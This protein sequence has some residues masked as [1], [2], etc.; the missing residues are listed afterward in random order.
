MLCRSPASFVCMLLWLVQLGCRDLVGFCRGVQVQLVY[1]R[2]VGSS[3]YL[4]SW[5]CASWWAAVCCVLQLV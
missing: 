2:L 1:G 4:S 3:W 5:Y